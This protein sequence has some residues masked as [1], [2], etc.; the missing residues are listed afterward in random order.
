M[1]ILITGFDPFNQ[2]TINPSIEAV[3][4]LPDV[5]EQAKIIK[6]EVPTV[7]N[8]SLTVIKEAIELHQPDIVISVGQAGGRSS[9]AIERMGINL[10]DA[11]I[12]DNASQQMND[13]KIIEEAPDGYF[14]TLPIK[15]IVHDLK[16][17]NIPATISNSA[18]TFVCNHVLFGILHYCKH[19][20]PHIKSGFI[21][22]PFLPQQVVNKNNVASMGL[23]LIVEGLIIAIKACINYDRDIQYKD[24]SIF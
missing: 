8:T 11:S 4:K 21:H 19:F 23:E 24:G 10:N 18:G 7:F 1:K 22:I 6:L 3:K 16:Q 9:I 12:E 2:E 5:I 15:A 13:Q 14:S 17:A 20:H